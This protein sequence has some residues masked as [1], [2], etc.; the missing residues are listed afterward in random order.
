LPLAN[1]ALEDSTGDGE[2]RLICGLQPVREAV[3]AH[4]STLA[5]VLVEG[6]GR[7]ASPQLEAIAR[8]A[9]D[10]GARVERVARGELDRMARGVRHQGAIAL[11]PALRILSL[12]EIV[13]G[14]RAMLVAVDE[15]Q[16]PQNFG[17][18]IR[19]AVAMGATAV[20]W[21]EHRSAPLSPVTFRASAGAV[22]HATLCRVAALPRALEELR[23]RGV[24]CVGLD[25]SVDTPVDHIDLTGPV[26]LVV[27]AEGK[28]L[29]KT[30]KRVCDGLA[31]LPMPG[32]I[33]SL[34]ASAAVAIALYEVVRQRRAVE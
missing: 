32:P 13:L 14:D 23:A 6:G 28:G 26:A 11:A 15:L 21:P 29:R 16:D 18:I 30:V 25:M 20:V 8:F 17:A 3:R 22:E 10:H 27:G 19:S 31:R 12:D 9:S 4:G 5:R 1:P 2:G 34:N 24:R 7:E 33:D